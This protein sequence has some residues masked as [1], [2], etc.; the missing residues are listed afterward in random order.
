MHHFPSK[1]NIIP[2]LRQG[3]WCA[4]ISPFLIRH[5]GGNTTR[6]LFLLIGVKSPSALGGWVGLMV[7]TKE[8]QDFRLAGATV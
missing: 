6:S 5:V 7:P 1:R 2:S 8:R 4:E 3:G